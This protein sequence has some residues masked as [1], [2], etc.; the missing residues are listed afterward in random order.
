[1]REI[2][3]FAVKLMMV[4]L[5]AGCGSPED[6][7]VGVESPL[8]VSQ[9]DEFIILST[10]Q[11]TASK[12]QELVSIDI[13]DS[14]LDGI[15]ILRTEPDHR[16]ATHVPID[17]TMSYVFKLPIAAGEQKVIKFYAKAI[18][19]GDHNAEIDFCINSGI[20]FLSRSIRTIVE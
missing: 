7:H 20:S 3:V 18:K 4:I 2:T 13:A 1:M 11:N 6:I 5:L 17:N 8:N 9:G 10:V 15:A 12:K 14:Y 16:E 19:H